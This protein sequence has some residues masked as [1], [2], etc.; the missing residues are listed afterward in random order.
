MKGFLST[1]MK[2]IWRVEKK[3]YILRW[4]KEFVMF[5]LEEN[6]A[7]KWAIGTWLWRESGKWMRLVPMYLSV[8]TQSSLTSR[9]WFGEQCIYS[10]KTYSNIC[11]LWFMS[12][13][14][15]KKKYS[16]IIWLG[17]LFIPPSPILKQDFPS[18][19]QRRF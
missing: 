15:L 8:I 9:L 1:Y 11:S 3:C 7:N 6:S 13:R 4:S 16:T 14:W 10:A 17:L 5:M 2:Q 12:T 19:G 18:R